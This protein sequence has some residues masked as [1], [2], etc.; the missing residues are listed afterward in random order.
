[1]SLLRKLYLLIY[2]V[3]L[4]TLPG[5][6]LAHAQISQDNFIIINAYSGPVII[7]SALEALYQDNRLFLPATY[8]SDDVEVPI[9]Y[10]KAENALTGWLEN[11]SNTVRVDFNKHTGRVGKNMFDVSQDDYLYYDDEIYLSIQLI[12]KILN[13]QSE[14]DFANQSL[15]VTSA[16]NLPFDLELSRRQKQKRFDQVAKEKEAARQQQLNKDVYTQSDWLQMPFIDLSARYSVSKNQG[17][18]TADNLSYTANASF[19][20]GGFDSE[21]NAYSSTIDDSPVLTFK[22]AREDETGHILGLFKHLEM[23]DTYSYSNAENSSNTPG[24]GFKMSTESILSPDDKTYTFRDALPLGWEVELYRNE[25]LLG[26]QNQSNNGYFEFADIPL[27]LGKNKFK[28]VFYGPQGQTKEKEEIIFFNGNILNR[29]KGR[30]RLN[31]IHKNRYLIQTRPSPRSSSRGHNAF[32]EAGYGLT[33]FLTLNVSAMA[34]SLELYE[35]WPP[36][37]MYRKD[38]EYVAGDLSLFAYGIFSSIGTVVDLEKSVATLN[39]YGQTSLWDWDVA[40]EHIHYGRAVLSRNLF[41]N[42]TME[43]ETTLRVNK[44]LSPFHLISIP[45]SY[46]LHHFSILNHAGTQT[47]HTVSVSQTLPYNIYLNA[48]YM[49]YDYYNGSFNRQL[50]LTANR[51]YGP[52]TLRGS[53]TYN[54]TYDRMYNVEFTA[55]RSLSDRLKF[56]A[57]YAYQSRSLSE[58]NYEGLYSANLSYLTKYG[59]L[60]F[61]AGTSNRHNTYAFIGYNVSFVPDWLNRSI[62]T[63]GS[64][65]QGTGAISSFAY[66]DTNGNGR[67][68]TDEETLPAADFTVKPHVNVY[69]SHKHTKEGN[70]LLTHVSAYRDVDIDVDISNVDDTLSL[71]NTAGTR[72]IKLRPAQVMYLSF[73][74][75]GTGDLEGTVYKVD[76]KGKRVPFRGALVNLYKDGQLVGNKVS[77][78]DG[79]YSFPQVPLGTYQ[80]RLDESQAKD[81]ELH[82]QKTITV[83]LKEIEQFEVRDMVLVPNARKQARTT[84]NK[85]SSARKTHT[86][87][88]VKRQAG[89]TRAAQHAKQSAKTT[90]A[91]TAKSSQTAAPTAV[92]TAQQPAHPWWDQMKQKA[93]TYYHRYQGYKQRFLQKIKN[94]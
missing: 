2:A 49:H 28:L 69:D 78:Y 58:H 33:D 29:G 22:T 32:I 55:H 80:I 79:Y 36:Q 19:L 18:H 30:L 17:Q 4:A 45:F 60:S 71:L 93:R 26:Y 90:S 23:G 63:T 50:M 39:F 53:T 70:T 87:T 77:E 85:K 14:F 92:M 62:Y 66:M 72:T 40:F 38:K 88:A 82:Q 61:E 41:N 37:E 21:F 57:R 84:R 59:Y 5:A 16:G 43:N 12:D 94:D 46:S 20:T 34:D 6:P 75:V 25:E 73:P 44:V 11:H 86:R 35:D 9:T 42:T 54:F 13:T 31:Y 48:Q 24:V 91:Q 1:M 64:K 51:I 8:L 15:K 47:E 52:W 81:L 27:L 56:G 76:A 7:N 83:A 89:T 65:V 3:L 68:D 67:F 74:I 10:N